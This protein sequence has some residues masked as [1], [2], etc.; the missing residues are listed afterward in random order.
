MTV[1]SI[2]YTVAARIQLVRWAREENAV[3][4]IETAIL[5]PILISLLMGCYDIGRG[6]NVNQ[7]T[8]A[9]AQIIGDLVARDRS[10]TMSSLQDIV[11]AGRL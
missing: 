5:F 4:A 2:L 7:K 3:A 6:L 1:H 10:V 9:A 8:I 11:E